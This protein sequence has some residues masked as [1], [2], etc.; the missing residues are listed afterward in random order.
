M[1]PRKIRPI[2]RDLDYIATLI[3][4]LPVLSGM[5]IRA[6]L[7]GNESIDFDVLKTQPAGPSIIGPSTKLI[8]E[9]PATEGS[10]RTP[11]YEDVGGAKSQMQRIREM[12]RIATSL[13]GSLRTAGHQT[14]ARR[15]AFMDLQVAA[16]RL[17]LVRSR[18]KPMRTSL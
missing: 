8:I 3:D 1:R 10:H 12:I 16:R 4:G 9:Q 14:T 17:S 15:I 2:E 18:M 6:T 13:S 11:S 5:C 7:F